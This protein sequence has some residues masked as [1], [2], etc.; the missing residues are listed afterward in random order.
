MSRVDIARKTG[1]SQASV[2]GITA[3][4]IE[5]GLLFEKQEG[6]SI[7]GRR[8]ILLAINPDGAYT[9][10]VFLS[11]QRIS[12]VV[13][14]MQADILISAKRDLPAGIASPEEI[15]GEIVQAVQKA[16]WKSDLAK[17]QISGVGI[18]LPGL[19]DSKSGSVQFLPN[20]QWRNVNLRDLVSE[21]LEVPTYIENS[22]NTITI[23]EQWFGKG[24]GCSDF[25][26]VNLEHGIGSG[27]V[28]NGQLYRGSSGLAG[29]FGHMIVDPE[30]P[31]CRC[32]RQGC[33]E[34]I[35]GNNAILRDAGILAKKGLWKPD[36]PGGITI[37]EIIDKAKAGEKCLCDIYAKAGKML[38]MGITNLIK[39]FNP[40]LIIFSGKGVKAGELLFEPMHRTI[41]DCLFE[42]MDWDTQFVVQEWNPY[43]NARGAGAL[44]LQEVYKSPANRVVPVI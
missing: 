23:G 25:T 11:I 20:Y 35:A 37:E 41:A 29:E 8:P 36:D 5:E 4:L 27:I 3:E 31:V 10:G 14:N 39:L 44:V 19:V 40:E 2:T 15:A 21:Q 28:I 9:I 32:G 7:G 33:L 6:K 30:G 12:V 38:G 16:I 42:S 26:M 24:R 22:A 18:A 17:N 34:A 13:I 1:L 43:N